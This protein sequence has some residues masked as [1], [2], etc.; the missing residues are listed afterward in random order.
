MA[1][2]DFSDPI[3]PG[4]PCG[5]PVL[6]TGSETSRGKT[7]LLLPDAS[8]LPCGVPND[9]RASPSLAGLPTPPWPY[10]R[11]LYVSSEISSSAFFRF[12]LATDTLA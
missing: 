10:I 11:F 2:A 7:C 12:R 3:P 9:Y 6:W 5:S 4:C 1:S 8:D